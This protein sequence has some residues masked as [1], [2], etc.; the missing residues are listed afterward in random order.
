MLNFNYKPPLLEKS[1]INSVE[2]C[3]TISD[4]EGNLL[5]Y[6]NGVN[7][8]NKNHNLMPNGNGLG[9][10]WSSTQSACIVKQ[11]GNLNIYYLFTTS[12]GEDYTT[13]NYKGLCYSIVDMNLNS[14]LGDI[15]PSSKNTLLLNPSCEKIAATFHSNQRDIWIVSRNL[16]INKYISYLLTPSGIIDSIFSNIGYDY[17][18][19]T[20]IGPGYLKFSFNSKYLCSCINNGRIELF[21]F[22]NLLGTLNLIYK[23]STLFNSY[24][25]EFSDNSKYL[26]ISNNGIYRF[27]IVSENIT[28]INNSKSIINNTL[29]ESR[30]M[31]IGNDYN[32]YILN[33]SNSSI[34]LIVEPSDTL[35]TRIQ[36]NNYIVKGISPYNSYGLQNIYYFQ[37]PKIYAIHNCIDDTIRFHISDTSWM[38]KII[39]DFGDGKGDTSFYPKHIYSDTGTYDVTATYYYYTCDS[40]RVQ[41]LRVN[42]SPLAINLDIVNS[43]CTSNN[44]GS[45]T[46]NATGGVSPY[47]YY[48][49]GVL[50]STNSFFNLNAGSYIVEV[51]DFNA[52]SVFESVN[53]TVPI[54]YSIDLTA[55]NNIISQGDKVTLTATSTSV[56]PIINYIWTPY[57]IITCNSTPICNSI[58][59]AP[60]ETT[61]YT[62]TAINEDSCSSTD[63]ITVFVKQDKSVFIPTVFSPNGDSKNETFDIQILGAKSMFVTIWDR[64]GEKV[65]QNE[66]QQNGIGQGWDGK[67]KGKEMT[68]DNYTYQIEVTYNDDKKEIFS[69]TFL[70]MK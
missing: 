12:M 6:T 50:Q 31:Q 46:I 67:F 41:K 63:T 8:W 54:G 68:T 55:S 15:I 36:L 19:R 61:L 26:Y 16:L 69:G 39:W 5:F 51:R 2:G 43:T 56:F 57:D 30:G 62:V 11:P 58:T 25:C 34:N 33:T 66:N 10:G 29:I 38:S 52:C 3:A 23:D 28:D 18:P 4:K 64:W 22:N 47:T 32:I 49:N 1:N 60:E 44:N 17:S 37:L 40:V 13:P 9:G 20:D 48:L 35:N 24:G 7:V 65:Y 21:K 53:I 27:N 14:G 70:L 42:I 45:I 59:S